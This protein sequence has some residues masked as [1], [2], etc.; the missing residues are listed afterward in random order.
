[1]CSSLYEREYNEAYAN[2]TAPNSIAAAI[3]QVGVEL[4]TAA[5]VDSIDMVLL[6][7]FSIIVVRNVVVDE[8]LSSNEGLS[9]IV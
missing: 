7:S 9:E 8:F 6:C 4:V 3:V 5:A 2:V 1:M